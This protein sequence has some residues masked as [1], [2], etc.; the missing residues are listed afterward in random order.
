[1]EIRNKNANPDAKNLPAVIHPNLVVSPHPLS[2]SVG[3]KLV[4]RD[5]IPGESLDEY[6]IRNNFMPTVTDSFVIS[7]NGKVVDFD[8]LDL[9][10]P[11]MGDMI[12]MRARVHDGGGDGGSNPLV[13]VLMIAVLVASRNPALAA[14]VGAW[15]GGGAAVGSAIIVIGGMLL[16]SA[17]FPANVPSFDESEPD[18]TYAL[19]GS[20]NRTRPYEPLPVVFGVVKMYPDH[21]A[22]PFT[23][24]EGNDQNLMQIFNFGLTDMTV[25]DLK[26][27]DA[28]ID[29]F[30]GANVEPA[31]VGGVVTFDGSGDITIFP[32]NVDTLAGGDLIALAGTWITRTS[33][34]GA[35]RLVCDL[36]GVS[37]F[38]GREEGLTNARITLMAEYRLSGTSD[39]WLPFFRTFSSLTSYTRLT[40]TNII[41]IV[42]GDKEV[43]RLTYHRPVVAGTY[44]VR[45]ML[46]NAADIV[47]SIIVCDDDGANCSIGTSYSA[48][49]LNVGGMTQILSWDQLKSWQPDTGD[50]TGQ[51]R[52]ALEIRAN[53][54]LQGRVDGFNAIASV[55][56]PAWNGSAWVNAVSSNPADQF[57]ALA[58]GAFDT[59][60]RRLWGA[61]LP[62]SRIDIPSI[63]LWAE[64]CEA[65]SLDCNIVLTA[66]LTVIDMLNTVARV[67]RGATTWANG[68]LGVVFDEENKSPVA[69]FGMSNI[70]RDS[71][72]VNYISE[73]QVDEVV[74]AFVNPDIGWLRDTV[75]VVVPDPSIIT[76]INTVTI[77]IQGVTN[78]AQAAK[79]A[80]LIAAQQYYRRRIMSWETDIEGLT[81][82]RGDVATLS[83]DVTQWDYSGRLVAG[84]TTTQLQLDREV[85]YGTAA[86]AG[87][88][89]PDGTYVV[90]EVGLF[91]GPTD[92]LLLLTPL[93][94]VP[95]NDVLNDVGDY[96]WFF[97]PTATPGKLVKVT[98]VTPL[99]ENRV[100]IVATDEE[101]DYYLSES[102]SYTY[103]PPTAYTTDIPTIT[104]LQ[105]GESLVIVGSGFSSK[106]NVSWNV[107][108]EY[109]GAFIRA[110][111]ED[112]EL[113]DIGRTLD[114]RFDFEW[115]TGKTVTVEVTLHNKNFEM[116]D[117]SR[118]TASKL[119]VGK[120]ALP[121][122]VENF[123]V[124]Q[125]GGV[126]IM[127]WTQV[128]DVDLAGYEIRYGAVSISTY[129]NAT[130]LT[131]V[132]R[133]TNVTSADLPPGTW[134]VFIKAVDTSG[135]YSANAASRDIVFV[136]DRD[137]IVQ[138]PQSPFDI[139]DIFELYD[140]GTSATVSVLFE[141]AFSI[142]GTDTYT[143][144]VY[145][146][147]DT[148]TKLTRFG[149]LRL[150]FTGSTTRE[151]IECGF[152]TSNGNVSGFGSFTPTVSSELMVDFWNG[153]DFWKIT[154]TIAPNDTAHSTAGIY[155][156][157][158]AGSGS[159]META[160]LDIAESGSINI[161]RPQLLNSAGDVLSA[162][163]LN[164]ESI[165][166]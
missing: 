47:E 133:G 41:D 85:E 91:V 121:A 94:T 138:T 97:G 8:K 59:S 33:S 129:E 124:L 99:S 64:W 144:E 161:W 58:R 162:D 73:N 25:S 6:L 28:P 96:L 67:G 109:G 149:L 19:S 4:Y 134:T 151:R 46:V 76:P 111:D 135:N 79:E 125:N 11:R 78:E 71:F 52:L 56:I 81:V 166:K 29:N 88:R 143:V 90:N 155:I 12:V 86:F 13:I 62:D 107:S 100:R 112:T 104:D 95:D 68:L 108:G 60:G 40:N 15:V 160:T 117:V 45:M 152:D 7:V 122:D 120:M 145:V 92:T 87:V 116:S 163:G 36:S 69:M 66:K 16:I 128:A 132:T 84:P 83:H 119:L 148:V 150:E 165:L 131:S 50:Y 44:D 48:R 32:S 105:L 123:V 72:R 57:L 18:P 2:A 53:A 21:A 37:F 43:L 101:D 156:L 127:K 39:P 65:K 20:A 77:E 102:N 63:Q 142:D 147:K 118:A 22:R 106:V 17:L 140:D 27:G 110:G 137:V 30:I 24:Y 31:S 139:M 141:F 164:L 136:S 42:N 34:P 55:T 82:Q 5:F 154:S 35:T 49:G 51:R 98:D 93:P 126:A 146:Q 89:Y 114:Q 3:R 158:A 14:Q 61:G 153:N 74:V 38:I 115:P 10:F 80:N 9:I 130:P 75:R 157:P 1:M 23:A 54:Q 103:V 113:K 159:T 26:I 70:I